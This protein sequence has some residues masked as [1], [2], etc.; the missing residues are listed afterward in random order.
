MQRISGGLAVPKLII[1]VF[2]GK[3]TGTGADIG[4][5]TCTLTYFPKSIDD[6]VVTQITSA[7]DEF[8][9]GEVTG[10]TGKII[11]ITVKRIKFQRVN[12]IDTANSGGA[13]ADPHTHNIVTNSYA[14]FGSKVDSQLLDAVR[15]SYNVG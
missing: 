4:K 1:D 7:V 11:E 2:T 8:Y 14:C 10:L 15:V 13:G 12:S 5:I 9:E 3:T 6:I